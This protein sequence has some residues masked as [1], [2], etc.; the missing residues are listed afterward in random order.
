MTLG[1]RLRRA[2]ERAGIS[3]DELCARTKIK[4][5][6]L[7]AIERGDYARV[8][9]GLFVRGFLRAY[10][11]EVGLDPEEIVAAYL[12]E[13]EPEPPAP[14]ED[15]P[16]SHV[17]LAQA[18]PFRWPLR[19]AW[20][21]VVIAGFVVAVLTTIGETPRTAA[22]SDA[23]PVGTAGVVPPQPPPAPP[24]QP[25]AE[26]P[27]TLTMDLRATRAV[28]VAATADGEK[29]VYRVLQADERVQVVAQN[30]IAARVGDADAL[31]YTLN[32]APGIKLGAPAEVRDIRIT[33][34]NYQSFRKQ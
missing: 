13:F 20:P 18:L 26:R 34:D 3:L 17:N 2:R 22:V 16:R 30:E 5:S 19:K 23:Q 1:E 6:I 24:P 7:G 12:D 28:W 11:R 29:V 4:V 21:M 14:V 27:S 25:V 10:A 31:E 33:P 15:P 32:G 8:P 9:S